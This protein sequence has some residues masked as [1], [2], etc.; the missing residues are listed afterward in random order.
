MM[1]KK[2][3]KG[4]REARKPKQA[5]PAASATSDFVSQMNQKGRDKKK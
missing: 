3:R 1:S 2:L 5:K 4:N